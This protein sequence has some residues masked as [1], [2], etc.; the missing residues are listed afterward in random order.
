MIRSHQSYVDN[1]WL[2]IRGEV[3]NTGATDAE[4]VKLIVTLYD[5][6]GN[7]IGMDFT[8]TEL[9]IVP[10]GSTSPFES[11]TDHW[12]NFDHYDIQV[13]GS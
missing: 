8:Y 10:A 13:E 1:G 7:V 9:D 3:E 12:P 5:A 4:Y 11:G 2:H 6:S